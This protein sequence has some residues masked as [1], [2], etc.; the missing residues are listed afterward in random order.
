MQSWLVREKMVVGLQAVGGSHAET[1][2]L[3]LALQLELGYYCGLGVGRAK[4]AVHWAT[5]WAK[6]KRAN[7]PWA[8]SKLGNIH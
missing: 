8:Q 4:R 7:G 2:L 6:R 3:G 1:G 5:V